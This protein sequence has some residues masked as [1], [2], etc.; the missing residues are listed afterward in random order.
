MP[1]KTL[2]LNPPSFENFDGGASSRWPA[3]REIE[4]YW[5]PVWL[6]YPAGLLEGSRLL[7]AP[8]HHVSAEETIKICKDYEFLV[9]FTSTVGWEGDQR[10]AEAIKAANPSIRIAF[11]GPPVTTDPDRALNECSV[12]DFICRREFDYSVVEFA[13]G[14][15]LN[16]ILGISYKKDGKIVHNPDRPQVEDLDAM[17]WATKIY[18]RDMDVTRYNVPF[19]LHPYIA[20]YSTRGCPAQCTFCL[21]PQTLSGHAWRKRST[22]DVAAEMAWAKENFPEVKEFFF[23]DDTFNIQKARTIE[24]CEKLQAA[25]PHLELHLARHHRLRHPEGHARS[26]LPPA[27]RGLRVRRSA[28]PQE[29]QEGRHRRARARHSPRTATTSASPSTPT[30]SSACPARPR[31]RSATPSTLPRRSTCET[32]QVSVAHAYPGTEFYEYAP[33]NGFIT[34]E[35]M[36]DD[37][38]HQMAH[39]EY[40]GL[41]TD[42]VMEMV[43]RFYDEYYFRPKAAFRVVWKAIVNRDVPRLYVEAKAF[44]KLRAQRNKMVKDARSQKAD[45]PRR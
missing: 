20:L 29:H 12:L 14:K 3:T 16:E 5:Y 13:Q 34:N 24:L 44:L 1:L 15:P 6:T 39:I 33:R 38:G 45:P 26:R 18:K 17:P 23:D 27:D 41:P 2:L 37:G 22:D 19:L 35:K 7:D 4:S 40:P 32:I 10:L 25:R 8:P 42:Y 31:S 21:W 36:E 28:D 11:V 9:L 30:S 43:H